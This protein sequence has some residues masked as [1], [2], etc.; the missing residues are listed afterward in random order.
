MTRAERVR[1]RIIAVAAVAIWPLQ[2][3]GNVVWSGC[4]FARY[5]IRST[6][7]ETAYHTRNE[8]RFIRECWKAKDL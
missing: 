2:I 1:C 3:I 5:A 7:G 8:W 4:G 6:I